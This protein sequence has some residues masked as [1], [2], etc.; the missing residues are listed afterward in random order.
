MGSPL[1][2]VIAFD[3]TGWAGAAIVMG[4]LELVK[5]KLILPDV[6]EV[7]ETG[8]SVATNIS[9]KIRDTTKTI[10]VSSETERRII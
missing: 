6:D 9:E 1:C 10:W 2:I 5:R 8:I 4:M 3:K 7:L